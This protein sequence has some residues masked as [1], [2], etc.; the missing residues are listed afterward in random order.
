MPPKD[1]FEILEHLRNKFGA[2]LKTIVTQSRLKG[3]TIGEGVCFALTE[4]WFETGYIED[5]E[6]RR[7][8]REDFRSPFHGEN[9]Q[10]P[11]G[12][13]K[14]QEEAA[15]KFKQAAGSHAEGLTKIGD[16]GYKP[17]GVSGNLHDRNFLSFGLLVA[18]KVANVNKPHPTY[19]YLKL[20]QNKG[21]GHVVG[22]KRGKSGGEHIHYSLFDA[23][24]FEFSKIQQRFLPPFLTE[25]TQECLNE[26]S[27]YDLFQVVPPVIKAMDDGLAAMSAVDFS[28]I[29]L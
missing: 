14:R 12:I 1:A 24:Y 25:Y 23:N 2:K 6:E 22:L 15:R 13:K 28:D 29:D 17:T 5:E 16:M 7:R 9:P 19:F 21:V 18:A 3:V 27:H 20:S 26:Y 8:Q 4:R 11:E 10:L